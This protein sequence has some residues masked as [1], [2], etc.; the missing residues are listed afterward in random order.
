M[1][2]PVPDTH[3]DFAVAIQDASGLGPDARGKLAAAVRRTL[4]RAGAVRAQIEIAIV[5]DAS[6]REINRE[7]L[8]HDYATD[9][10]TFPY[11]SPGE[12]LSGEIVISAETAAAVAA[13]LGVSVADELALY[14]VHGILHLLG[15][16][17]IAAADAA[18]MR[19]LERLALAEEDESAA[20][21]REACSQ[22]TIRNR[23]GGPA[24]NP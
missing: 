13:D 21:F 2:L 8:G 12:D 18:E 4:S 1:K 3:E 14:A 23:G 6:I 17:D 9:V 20:R 7:H 24:C 15:F 10:I 19:E 16:D 11:S 22:A 5:N